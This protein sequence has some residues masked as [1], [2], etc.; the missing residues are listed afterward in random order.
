MDHTRLSFL[1][2]QVWKSYLGYNVFSLVETVTMHKR[3]RK[4]KDQSS[5]YK[6]SS[7]LRS[8]TAN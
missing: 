1:M 2:Y 5:V 7:Q 8:M 6:V 4:E 3:F